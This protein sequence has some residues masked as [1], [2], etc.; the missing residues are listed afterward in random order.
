MHCEHCGEHVHRIYG[1]WIG[2]QWLCFECYDDLKDEM[3]E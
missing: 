2:G 3:E 1:M